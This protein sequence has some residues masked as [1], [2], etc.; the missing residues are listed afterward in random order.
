MGCYWISFF[1]FLTSINF[2]RCESSQSVN[3][4]EGNTASLLCNYQ[5]S[6]FRSLIWYRQYPGEKLDLLIQTYNDGNKSEGRFTAEIQ[7]KHSSSVLYVPAAHVTDSALYVC[8]AEAH[9]SE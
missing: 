7:K 2:G 5:E 1:I 8:A 3:V 4:V 9:T 6:N